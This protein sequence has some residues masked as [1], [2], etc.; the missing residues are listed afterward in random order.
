MEE[1]KN[2]PES[3]TSME[4][5]EQGEEASSS[6]SDGLPPFQ[7][8]ELLTAEQEKEL[9]TIIQAGQKPEATQEEKE[10]SKRAVEKMVSSNLGLVGS[11]LRQYSKYGVPN[12]DLFQ[13]GSIG[14]QTAAEK[15]DPS[16]GTRFSTYATYWIKESIRKALSAQGRAIRI[17]AHM[18]AKIAKVHDAENRLYLKLGREPTEEE[19]AEMLPEFETGEIAEILAIPSFVASLD[20]PLKSGDDDSA[21]L[22]SFQSG[23]DDPT[24]RL[25]EEDDERI[26]HEGLSALDEREK[27]IICRLYGLQGYEKQD[28]AEVGRAYGRSRE[29]I[30]QIHDAAIIKMK[31]RI[32]SH[33]GKE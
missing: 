2:F 10:A 28:M 23:D 15:F 29:R 14:L 24:S 32:A 7:A 20:D 11:I 5:E 22:L 12:E 17:P 16:L 8:R 33:G 26:V 25:D 6:F 19:I 1:E 13:E 3:E 30:R 18:A 4:E 31:R 21:D 9:G 27:D